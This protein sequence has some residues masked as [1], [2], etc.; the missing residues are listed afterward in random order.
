MRQK[1]GL[2]VM[3]TKKH[4]RVAIGAGLSMMIVGCC[5]CHGAVRAGAAPAAERVAASGALPANSLLFY[6]SFDETLEPDVSR[7]GGGEVRTTGHPVLTEG[8][9]GQALRVVSRRR[10]GRR[11]PSTTVAYPL[12]GHLRADQ[13][14]LAFWLSAEDWDAADDVLQILFNTD[15]RRRFQIQNNPATRSSLDFQWYTG[16]YI[17]EKVFGFGRVS[18]PLILHETLVEGIE[19]MKPGVWYHI[20]YTWQEGEIRAYRNG[21]HVSTA[22]FPRFE[23]R[24]TD[25]LGGWF[26]LG[27]HPFWSRRFITV[28]ADTEGRQHDPDF[29]ADW[30]PLMQQEFSTL[31]DEFAIFDRPLNAAHIAR[32]S[33]LGVRVFM[34]AEAS[35]TAVADLSIRPLPTKGQVLFSAT[36]P[37]PPAAAKAGVRI[38]SVETP[39]QTHVIPLTLKGD[40]SEGVLNTRDLSPGVYDVAF[41]LADANGKVLARNDPGQTFEL[42][43]PEPWWGN[44]L[45]MDDLLHDIVPPPWTPM[46][47]EDDTIACWGRTI[48][49]AGAPLPEQ[50]VSAGDNLLAAPM[51]LDFKIDGQSLDFRE[52]RAAY[53]LESDVAVER[54]WTGEADGVSLTV[55]TR[56]EFDGFMWIKIAVNNASG[57]PLSGL[58]YTMP[59]VQR[60]ARFI[61]TPSRGWRGDP[62]PSGLNTQTPWQSELGSFS[63]PVWLGG[64]E[65]GIQWMTEGRGGWFNRDTSDEIRVWPDDERVT[66]AVKLIDSPCDR[67]S[68]EIAFG[69]HPTP[70]K[71]PVARSKRRGPVGVWGVVPTLPRPSV[72]SGRSETEFWEGDRRRRENNP[73]FFKYSFLN[74]VASYYADGEEVRERR[75]YKAEWENMPG[76]ERLDP[77]SWSW[78]SACSETSYADWWVWFIK[79]RWLHPDYGNMAGIYFDHG[80][81]VY[82]RHPLHDGKC[83]HLDEDDVVQPDYKIVAMRNLLK[84]IY[85]V[86]KGIDR[87]H[88][89]GATPDY[90]VVLHTSTKLIAPHIAFAYVFD[91]ETWNVPGGRF[92]DRL[93]LDFM[94]AEWSHTPWGYDERGTC[95]KEAYYWRGFDAETHRELGGLFQAWS[96]SGRNPD[97][98]ADLK[99]HPRYDEAIA[100]ALPRTRECNAMFLLFDRTALDPALSYFLGYNDYRDGLERMYEAFGFYEDDVEFKGYWR[101]EAIIAGQ[102]ENLKASLYLRSQAGK[103]LLLITNLD[104]DPASLALRLDATA[105]GLNGDLAFEHAETGVQIAAADSGNGIWTFES[106][107]PGRD[108]LA[109]L[110]NRKEKEQE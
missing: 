54:T 60:N 74:S 1:W 59:C 68:F 70:I 51:T 9:Q 58:T 32:L 39:G 31:I 3:E 82:C 96:R 76:Y 102:H 10:Q 108:Y 80:S 52:G 109:I 28:P 93:T 49:F 90:A 15:G 18:T 14:T 69:L 83:G 99:A 101:T 104:D 21:E 13:G 6:A 24:Q 16:R 78:F 23:A 2:N 56:T 22:A 81:P 72:A 103:A 35:G 37:A 48:R 12:P 57:R 47:V 63:N 17:N 61:H 107:V 38:A 65:R 79:N 97:R 46:Y 110:V 106:H 89:R 26:S 73:A 30:A 98:L 11:D 95:F 43:A 8:R 4:R 45:G 71:P 55:H 44:T 19:R 84:R 34:E 33:R 25:E 42:A 100:W 64:H 91:G 50:I 20:A 5:C 66:L 7:A 41:L 94:A 62:P 77:L 88:P 86:V 75:W 92:M 27:D 105:I 87:E 53:T 40:M 36:H 85:M 67:E 29:A